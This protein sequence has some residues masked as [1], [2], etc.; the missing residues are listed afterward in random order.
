MRKSQEGLYGVRKDNYS[1]LPEELRKLVQLLLSRCRTLNS[2][3]S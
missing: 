1:N 3:G 2:S